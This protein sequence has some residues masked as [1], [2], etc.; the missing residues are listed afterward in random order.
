MTKENRTYSGRKTASSINGAGKTGKLESRRLFDMNHSNIL[1][2]PPP[3]IMTIKIQ[4]NQGAL[5]NFKSFCTAKETIKKTKKGG[6][7]CQ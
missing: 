5:I 2:D 4:I 7:L 3:R 1:F 6:N